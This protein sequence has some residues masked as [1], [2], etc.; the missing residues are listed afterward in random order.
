MTY[1]SNPI[2]WDRTCQSVLK[3]LSS[4]DAARNR[5]S[6]VAGSEGN[7]LRKNC[8]IPLNY[9]HTCIGFPDASTGR[10]NAE[11]PGNSKCGG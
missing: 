4:G 1:L 9:L 11:L 5:D 6:L 10:W 8:Q 7:P 3:I 2:F